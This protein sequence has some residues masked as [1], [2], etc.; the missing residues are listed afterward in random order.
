MININFDFKPLV[1]FNFLFKVS[2]KRIK[3][4]G[5]CYLQ[6]FIKLIR[7]IQNLIGKYYFVR[8]WNNYQP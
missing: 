7:G 8:L 5:G 4:I 2:F 3:W 6:S 1:R